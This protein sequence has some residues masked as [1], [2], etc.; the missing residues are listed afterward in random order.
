MSILYPSSS[1]LNDASGVITLGGQSQLLLA[2]LEPGARVL[3]QVGNLYDAGLPA[4]VVPRKY[5]LIQNN[6]IETLWFNY[7]IAAILGKP[8]LSIVAGGYYE[9]PPHFISNEAVYIIGATT[10]SA[11]TCKWA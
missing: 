2:V 9:S 6:S 4:V 3:P 8:S 7:S 1:K 11:F 5:L 10:S